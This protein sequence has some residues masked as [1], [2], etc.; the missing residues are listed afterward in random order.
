MGLLGSP[1]RFALLVTGIACA[2]VLAG[3]AECRWPRIDPTGERV[4]VPTAA[5]P[6]P[7][8]TELPAGQLSCDPVELLLAPRVT[9]APVGSEVVLLAGVAGSDNYLRMNERVD[10]AISGGSVGQF[11]DI[12]KGT[13]W[14]Y[15]VGDF[16]RPRIASPT[17][18]VGSTS[19]RS[20][21]LT[22]GTPTPSDDVFVKEGQTWITVTSPVEGSTY[23]TAF[24]R[25]VYGWDRHKQSAIIHWVDAQWRFP[26]PA[27]VPAGGRQVLTTTVTR[28]SD[29]CPSAGYRVRYTISGGPP[30]GF[31]PSGAPTVD[32][33]TNAAG[34]AGAEIVQQRPAAGTSVVA[35][36]VIRP[37][38]IGAPAGMGLV[39]GA[40]STVVTWSAPGIAVRKTGPAV[41]SVGA[42]LTYRIEVS[43]SG[44]LPAD[45]V[46][47]TDE[48]PEGTSYASSS[49]AGQLVAGRLQWQLGRLGPGECRSLE[50]NVRANRAGPLSSC[51]EAA[52]AG[53]LRAR[54]CVTTTV[55][56]TPPGPIVPF[57]TPGPAVPPAGRAVPP[58]TFPGVPGAPAGLDV[59]ITGPERATVGEKVRFDI[60]I[61]NRGPTTAT[62]LSIIDKFDQGLVNEQ[63]KQRNEIRSLWNEDL[64]PGVAA[65]LYVEFLVAKAGRL[66]HNVEVTGRGGLRAAAQSCVTAVEAGVKPPPGPFG[67]PPFTSPGAA[68]RLSVKVASDATT[69]SVGQRVIVDI[70]VTNE[71]LQPLTNVKVMAILDPA[72]KATVATEDHRKEPIGLSW[73]LASLPP[74]T[75]HRF[76]IW[77]QPTQPAP[78][79]YV[80]AQVTSDQGVQG[81]D[82][83][84]LPIRDGAGPI[85][86][87]SGMPGPS[88]APGASA[89]DVSVKTLHEPVAV[90][91]VLTYIVRVDN[92]GPN[93]V[94]ERQVSV[95][96]QIPPEMIPV[97]L[98][99]SGPTQPEFSGQTV[100]FAPA[101]RLPPGETLEYRVLVQ[102]KKPGKVRIQAGVTS[103]SVRVPRL[104][105]T[106]TTIT[107]G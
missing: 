63:A 45:G 10:W 56:L 67:Q 29:Q 41:A 3:C 30:A 62:G 47:V 43:N 36:Q 90:S 34:Q 39:L 89:L 38:P 54:D 33:E 37:A 81:Q 6:N 15:L 4:F 14:D 52:T 104:G 74:R 82:S 75:P 44:D 77:C 42:T 24:A 71:G 83:V 70:D 105:E 76:E 17:Y 100:T 35:I 65:E 78:Q 1:R 85:P 50:V 87:T 73:T 80:Q 96:V 2:L 106:S 48:I 94:E 88:G 13:Y 31:A 46:V 57:T 27:I 49:A 21:R 55:S 98:G 28:Q 8:Y 12:E 7:R 32:V 69:A 66:C 23:V 93:A 53:G 60:T 107:E 99:T 16:T 58:G 72:L 9:V 51:A 103:Q 101:S 20:L 91:R 86:G 25:E 11:V 22:R 59:K 97:R 84:L 95:S 40:G 64:P 79:A 5:S 61:T 68:G 19:R 18:A 102:A 92:S 26:P